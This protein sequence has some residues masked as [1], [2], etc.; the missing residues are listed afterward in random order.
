MTDVN[1]F[2]VRLDRVI[3]ILENGAS[4]EPKSSAVKT[5]TSTMRSTLLGLSRDYIVIEQF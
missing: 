2:T 5:Y 4:T 1:Y 3:F